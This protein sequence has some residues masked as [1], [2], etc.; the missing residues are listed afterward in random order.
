M[1]RCDDRARYASS[2]PG[3]GNEIEILGCASVRTP[4][5]LCSDRAEVFERTAEQ[6]LAQVEQARP[7]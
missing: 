3:N 2:R 6:V 7:Q 1:H 4:E 5:A